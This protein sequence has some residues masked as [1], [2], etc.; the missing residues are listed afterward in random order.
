[1]AGVAIMLGRPGGKIGGQLPAAL[2]QPL[3]LVGQSEIHARVSAT[4]PAL[5]AQPRASA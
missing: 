2:L 5:H 3:L 1:M 4:A